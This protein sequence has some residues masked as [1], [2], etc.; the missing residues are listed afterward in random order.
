MGFLEYFKLVKAS[1]REAGKSDEE[2]KE[3]ETKAAPVAKKLMS[4]I[5]EYDVYG[6]ESL[7]PTAMWVS[8]TSF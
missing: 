7:D 2:V 4:E 1:M 5:D 3:F 8:V 6:G